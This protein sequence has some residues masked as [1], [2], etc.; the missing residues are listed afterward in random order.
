MTADDSDDPGDPAL[1]DA[2]DFGTWLSGLRRALAGAQDSEV[3]CG[4][5]TACCTSSQFVHVA[6][7]EVDA[8]AHIPRDLLFP[9][10]GLPPGH[11]VMGYDE[12]G[13][14]PMLTDGVCSIY[15]HRPRTCRTY[16]CRVFPATG[17]APDDDKPDIA[18]QARRWRF[19]HGSA[20]DEV[21]HDAVRAAAAYLAG[22]GA[23]SRRPPPASRTRL[24]V[25]AVEVHDLF[26][27]PDP[28]TGDLAV[29]SPPADEV[30]AA[31]VSHPPREP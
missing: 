30:D 14:C 25:L 29:I 17:I 12:R 11:R 1:L 3:P 24:A 20:D 4:G 19:T 9:A 22:A 10:P 8:L 7:D 23:P 2:G 5:C 13:H 27:R 16:D 21:R 28:A 18:R 31:V 6:P 15:A 26:V